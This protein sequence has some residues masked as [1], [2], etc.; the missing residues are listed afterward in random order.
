MTA[1]AHA[2]IETIIAGTIGVTKVVIP[3]IVPLWMMATSVIT[4][5]TA[6]PLT[7][8]CAVGGACWYLQGRFTRIE[9][10]QETVHATL[11]RLEK[12][13]DSRPCILPYGACPP[14]IKQQTTKE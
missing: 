13:I 5:E 11:D 7:I 4:E 8:V 2:M 1:H 9:S 12:K 3:P 6:L 14:V 10:H